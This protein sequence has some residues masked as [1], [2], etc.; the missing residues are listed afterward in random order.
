MS[1]TNAFLKLLVTYIIYM[2]KLKHVIWQQDPLP[3]YPGLQ[4]LLH[5]LH[6]NMH[7]SSTAHHSRDRTWS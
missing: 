6:T 2:Q 4:Y 3:H 7:I 1:H 5:L